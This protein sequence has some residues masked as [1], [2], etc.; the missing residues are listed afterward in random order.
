[1]LAFDL[2]V[3]LTEWNVPPDMPPEVAVP[4][5]A[6]PLRQWQAPA[7]CL[8]NRAAAR[9]KRTTGFSHSSRA[10]TGRYRAFKGLIAMWRPMC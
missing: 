1:M 5:C 10:Q 8:S 6:K 3:D 9:R 2:S 4:A 7:G